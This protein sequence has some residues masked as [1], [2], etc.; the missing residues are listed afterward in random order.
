MVFPP[1]KKPRVD[2]SS[3]KKPLTP[4]DYLEGSVKCMDSINQSVSFTDFSNNKSKLIQEKLVKLNI[5]IDGK[6]N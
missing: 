3:F 2:S 4:I 1:A 5:G 6:R